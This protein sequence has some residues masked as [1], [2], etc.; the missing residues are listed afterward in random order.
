MTR[1]A[2]VQG[3]VCEIRRIL[4]AFMNGQQDYVKMMVSNMFTERQSGK[5]FAH[6]D[7]VNCKT[8]ELANLVSSIN[9]DA[10]MGVTRSH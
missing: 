1:Y 9:Y 6:R 8:R 2:K 5:S 10:E 7:H 3:K 4:C